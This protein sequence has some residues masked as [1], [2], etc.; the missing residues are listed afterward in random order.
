MRQLGEMG[1]L[2]LMDARLG[3]VVVVDHERQIGRG[4]HGRRRLAH[5]PGRRSPDR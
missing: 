4:A 3:E 1:V 5:D 2:D